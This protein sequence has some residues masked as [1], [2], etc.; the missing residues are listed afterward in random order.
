[1]MIK[2]VDLQNRLESL[3]IEMARDLSFK[4]TTYGESW[5]KRGGGQ[6]FAVMWRKVD[7]IENILKTL[8]NGYDIFTAW[9]LNP[10]DIQD[11]VYDLAAYLM[12]LIEYKT[13]PERLGSI[14][15]SDNGSP[16][17]RS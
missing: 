2:S 15:L 4:N 13:R 3:A 8:D 7:R 9:D 5:C 17:E 16:A 12:L 1:M 6:A 14:P 11:D 10:G